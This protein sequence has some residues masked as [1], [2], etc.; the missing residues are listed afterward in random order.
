[1][2]N[3]LITS[4]STSVHIDD[5]RV[6]TNVFKGKTGNILAEQLNKKFNVTLLTSNT[7]RVIPNTYYYKTYDDLYREMEYLIKNNNF[8][9]IIHSAAIS[10][11]KVEGTYTKDLIK[12]DSDS[13]ISSDYKEL[14]LRLVQTRKIIDD[15]RDWGFDGILVKFKLQVGISDDELIEIAKKSMDHSRADIIVANCKEWARYYAYI[16]T[17][18]SVEKITRDL[19]GVKLEELF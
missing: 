7:N 3:I 5:V 4:G 11:Y 10:D 15:I 9:I 16:I 13:K 1:M 8:D 14:Y 6:I 18:N 2:K 17:N 19:L 12:I